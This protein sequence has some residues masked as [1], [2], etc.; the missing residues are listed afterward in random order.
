MPN[1]QK[2][3]TTEA[4]SELADCDDWQLHVYDFVYAYTRTQ[5]WVPER[6]HK[7][8]INM[9]LGKADHPRFLH[10]LL[11]SD[12]RM[13]ITLLKLPLDINADNTT[14]DGKHVNIEHTTSRFLLES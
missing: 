4:A 8:A 7:A 9:L 2:Q 5:P 12:S 3:K 10:S 11:D 6:V 13:C 1:I 14:L